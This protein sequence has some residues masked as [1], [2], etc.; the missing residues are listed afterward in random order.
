MWAISSLAEELF[1]FLRRNILHGICLLVISL[2]KLMS[3]LFGHVEDIFSI[4]EIIW[5]E[6]NVATIVQVNRKGYGRNG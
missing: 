6:C 1:N 5:L 3:Y 4:V 2:H